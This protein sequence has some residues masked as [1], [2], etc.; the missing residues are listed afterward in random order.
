MPPTARVVIAD[1]QILF[2][3]A[4][5]STLADAGWLIVGEA[6]AGDGLDTLVRQTECTLLLIDR[7]LPGISILEFCSSITAQYTHL[8][9]LLLASYEYEAQALQLP[10]FRA[11]AAGCLSKDHPAE[12]YR[13]ALMTL[14]AGQVIFSHALLRAAFVATQSIVRTMLSPIP[15]PKRLPPPLDHLTPREIEVL[16]LV[17]EGRANPDIASLLS[18]SS[19]TAMKH[20]S[21]IIDKLQVNNRMEAGLLYLKVVNG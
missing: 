19:H 2:R 18:I 3:Q 12:V 20:V 9:V 15:P 11:G 6:S 14:A 17:A 8:Q 16:A 21:H 7:A 5:V 10:A 1:H 13:T 4:L